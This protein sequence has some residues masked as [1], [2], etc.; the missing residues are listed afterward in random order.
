MDDTDRMVAWQLRN[1]PAFRSEFIKGINANLRGAAANQYDDATPS[2]R[3]RYAQRQLT[4]FGDIIGDAV[5]GA[6]QTGQQ[7]TGARDFQ[8]V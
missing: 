4:V 7:Q 3:Q 1:D 2:E 8:V 5:S 6:Q